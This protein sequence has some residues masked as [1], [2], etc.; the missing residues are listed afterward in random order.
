MVVLRSFL[1]SSVIAFAS[2]FYH[3]S[4]VLEITSAKAFKADVLAD[5]AL[6]IVEF[7]APWCG[8]CK[9]LAPHWKKAATLLKGVV[10][11]GAVD[12]SVEPGQSIAGP[13]GVQGFPTIKGTFRA[14]LCPPLCAHPCSL[15]MCETE[16][17]SGET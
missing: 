17:N 4:D 1:L 13:Y 10:K 5:D 16:Q 15:T 12:A 9:N 11:I 2:A 7:Y 3:G 14:F 6:W 8:H